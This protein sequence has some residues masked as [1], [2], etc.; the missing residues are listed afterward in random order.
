MGF[1]GIL[2]GRGVHIG[3]K[4]GTVTSYIKMNSDETKAYF[5]EL[6]ADLCAGKHLTFIYKNI[7]Q[8]QYVG[9]AK[10]PLLPAINSKKTY[11]K[12]LCVRTGTNTSIFFSNLDYKKLL[13]NT[14]QSISIEL[15]TET[16]RMV[17]F[18]GT[19]K[20]I[21]TLQFKKFSD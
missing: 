6:S 4:M 11:E 18:L 21:S 17:P 2:D 8:Y 16:K 5:G 13:S 1:T 10:S 20:V 19:G 14:I 3:Y 12:R 15:R 9:D 7:I